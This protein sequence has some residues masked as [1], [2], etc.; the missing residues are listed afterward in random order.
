MDQYILL[1][2]QNNLIIGIKATL[3][4]IEGVNF[5]FLYFLGLVLI[6]SFVPIFCIIAVPDFFSFFWL[7]SPT[8][9]KIP[10]ISFFFF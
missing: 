6:F 1:I 10:K 9:G 7:M 3:I 2:L 8:I 4:D 5:I